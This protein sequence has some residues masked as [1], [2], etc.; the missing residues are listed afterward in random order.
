MMYTFFPVG[1]KSWKVFGSDEGNDSN[2]TRTE[3]VLSI[4]ITW[5]SFLPK[6]RRLECRVGFSAYSTQRLASYST[7]WLGLAFST[8]HDG[9]T[10]LYSCT[11]RDATC[12]VENSAAATSNRSD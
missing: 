1:R 12:T 11:V 6:G 8:R 2:S 3:V 10:V 4:G 5:F 9:H 7:R